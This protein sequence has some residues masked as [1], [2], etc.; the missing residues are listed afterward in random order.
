MKQQ[1]KGANMNPISEAQKRFIV[2][3]RKK[4]VEAGL[5]EAAQEKVNPPSYEN[6]DIL[7][8][9]LKG[10]LSEPKA[11]KKAPVKRP[12]SNTPAGT[13][14]TKN[15]KPLTIVEEDTGLTVGLHYR[16]GV[17]VVE[18]HL[19]CNPNVEVRMDGKKL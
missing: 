19:G 10:L 11:P 5:N 6:A 13:I 12:D 4:C 3:L 18:I 17:P 1:L 2:G 8:K 7:I 16:N 9:K 15:K 14:W